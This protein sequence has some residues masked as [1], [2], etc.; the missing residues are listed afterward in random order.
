M[1]RTALILDPYCEIL[2]QIQEAFYT[3]HVRSQLCSSRVPPTDE[4]VIST[5]NSL[6]YSMYYTYCP[7]NGWHPATKQPHWT[8]IPTTHNCTKHLV[9]YP[10]RR[11]PPITRKFNRATSSYDYTMNDGYFVQTSSGLVDSQAD[12]HALSQMFKSRK[13]PI[14]HVVILDPRNL[15]NTQP[16]VSPGV[17]QPTNPHM[18]LSLN[19]FHL[20][21]AHLATQNSIPFT[22]IV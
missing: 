15:W 11:K 6:H 22:V 7:T 2:F 10:I 16:N 14:D 12:R 20:A 17:I 18:T 19:A 1:I 9:N 4:F 13:R 21:Q 5:S 8:Q 3:H